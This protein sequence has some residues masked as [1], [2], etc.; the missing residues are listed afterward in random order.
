MKLPL[1]RPYIQPTLLQDSC[2]L[3]PEIPAVTHNP[4]CYR[5]ILV[6]SLPWAQVCFIT[7][8]ALQSNDRFPSDTLPPSLNRS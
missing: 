7:K 2:A 1:A 6:H 8:G 3:N 5:H 4:Q